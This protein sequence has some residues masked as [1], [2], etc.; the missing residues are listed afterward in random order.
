MYQEKKYNTLRARLVIDAL[1]I[2]Q[3]LIQQPMLLQEAAEGCADAIRLRDAAKHALELA[4][5]RASRTLRE[6]DENGKVASE[7]KILSLIPLEVQDEEELLADAKRDAMYWQ[8]LADSFS[9]KGSALRRIAELTTSGYMA[10]N[11]AYL[12]RRREMHAARETKWR[13]R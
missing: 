10:P 7:Q 6:P 4:C 11:D 2:D 13:P 9:E 1:Q 5:A 3:E 12:E 8:G